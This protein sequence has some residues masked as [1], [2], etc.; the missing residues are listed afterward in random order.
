MKKI[1]LFLIVIPLLSSCAH[2]HAFQ[3]SGIKAPSLWSRWFQSKNSPMDDVLIVDDKAQVEHHWWKHFHDPVLDEL[4]QQALKNNK[5]LAIAKARVEEAG[6]NYGIGLS[7]QMPQIDLIGKPKRGNEGLGTS[8]KVRSIVDVNLQATWEMDIFG[9]NLPRLAQIQT[10]M[11]SQEAS[12]QGVM[13]GLLAQVG[14]N[15]FDLRNYEQQIVIT[16][17]N[18]E[19]QQK[20]L[21]LIKAQQKGAMVS[22]FDVERAGAQV[23]RTQSQLP[24]LQAAYEATLNRLNVLL[25]A[26]PGTKDFLLKEKQAQ[27][28]INQQV[29]VAAPATVLA[30]RPDVKAAERLY[31]ASISGREYAKKEIFPKITLLSFFGIQDSK[32]LSTYPWSVGITFIQP[33]LDFGRIQGDIKVARAQER[34]AFLQYQQTVLE[35]LEDMEN[36]LSGYKN[37]MVRNGFLK[38]SVE[39]NRKAAD[40]SKQQFQS[41]YTALLDVLVAERN[42][43]DAESDFADSDAKLRKDLIGIYTASGGGWL[44]E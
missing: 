34:Q 39:Q 40:L 8:D 36:A 11:Q 14:R 4:I 5:T 33:V 37:E 22:D 24:L 42:V 13:V 1:F 15:Y 28:P 16:K 10:I 29:V 32:L 41:G 20:T 12:R 43:L 3:S 35:A 19:N 27:E 18:L 44:V 6:A 2:P 23:S 31:A 9:R 26:V 21:D 7:N 17:K 25:G 30:N 38:T